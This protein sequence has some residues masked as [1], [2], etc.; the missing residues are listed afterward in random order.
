[1]M[2][3][4]SSRSFLNAE[5]MVAVSSAIIV[6]GLTLYALTST[7]GGMNAASS[8]SPMRL[9]FIL[10]AVWGVLSIAIII[11]AVRKSVAKRVDLGRVREVCLICLLM[12]VMTVG[13]QYVGYLIVIVVGLPL[14]LWRLGESSLVR[15]T[16]AFLILGPGMWFL[17]HHF[18][19]IRLPA[20]LPGG[21]F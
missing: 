5:I 13:F 12:I 19:G 6:G 18:L 20:I 4:V 8:D 9:P 16:L 2:A 14:L 1:M 17:F 7:G 10:L 21:L 15:G 11:R 3:K